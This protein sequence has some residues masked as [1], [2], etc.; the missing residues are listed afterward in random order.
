[1]RIIALLLF[2][3]MLIISGSAY[4]ESINEIQKRWAVANYE[5]ADAAQAQAFESLIADIAQQAETEQSAEL[6]IWKGIVESSYAGK[7]GGL[8]A[9][10][11]VKSARSALEAALETN[12]DALDGSAFTS[13]GALYYQVPP[14]PIAFGSN[15]KARRYLEKAIEINPDGIDSNYFYGAFLIEEKEYVAARQ[16]LQKAMQAPARADRPIADKG[17]RAEI[18]ALLTDLSARG[19]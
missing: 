4:A 6:L 7:A 8:D 19:V 10:G 17:R 18:Q 16:A 14:W 13:L 12:P 11:L 2:L 5:L 3:P 9:L 15:K 1:M